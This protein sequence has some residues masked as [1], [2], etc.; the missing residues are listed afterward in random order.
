MLPAPLACLLL[1]LIPE[2]NVAQKLQPPSFPSRFFQEVLS[3]KANQKSCRVSSVRQGFLVWLQ[4]MVSEQPTGMIEDACCDFET[5]EDVNEDLS[6]QLSSLVKSRY[7]RYWKVDLF[8]E[9]P[10]WKEDGS[11]M[12]RAC[13][14]E[15]VD[16]SSIPERWRMQRLS[17]VE[18]L[19]SSDGSN[20]VS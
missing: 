3:P 19:N 14:V 12:N 7:F 4:L 18:P 9:C 15:E 17:E 13:A 2:S 11:C 10:F 6:R 16:E 5:I 20:L 1:L 8:R